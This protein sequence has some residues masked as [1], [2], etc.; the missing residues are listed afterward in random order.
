MAFDKPLF[1]GLSLH[2]QKGDRAAGGRERCGQ[3]DTAAHHC[4][5]ADTRSGRGDAGHRREPS[6]YDQLQENLDKSRTIME[7][8]RETFPHMPDKDI[9]NAL[10]AF[11]LWRRR[12]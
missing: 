9:R 12:V 7:E 11:V 5:Q 6:Y 8:M 2:M 1:T 10:A 3:D 4:G